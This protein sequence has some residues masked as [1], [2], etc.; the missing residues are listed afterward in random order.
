MA[1]AIRAT[2]NYSSRSTIGYPTDPTAVEL[3][4]LPDALQTPRVPGL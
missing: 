2:A 3:Q 4:P 1:V